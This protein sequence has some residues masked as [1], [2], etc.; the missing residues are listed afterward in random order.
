MRLFLILLILPIIE[1]VLFIEVGGLIGTWPTIGLVVLTGILGAAL[2][3]R[4]GLSAL[5]LA[6]ARMA[7]GENPGWLLADGAMTLLAGV[8]LVV[9]GFFTDA[10][11]LALL[12]PAL[13]RWIWHRLAPRLTVVGVGAQ[14]RR[15][16]GWP[17]AGQTIEGEYEEV[18]V[19]PEPG[20]RRLGGHDDWDGTTG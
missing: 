19:P 9:P 17:P 11:G 13:R 8:L 4:Q 2:V 6:R 20:P 15:G 12:V 14:G 16:G 3:R 10:L 18:R 1:I 7:A 5:R